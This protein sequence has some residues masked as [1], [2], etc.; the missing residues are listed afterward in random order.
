ME[1]IEIVAESPRVFMTG[2]DAK[3][4][5]PNAD[6]V[7]NADIKTTAIAAPLPSFAESE[8]LKNTA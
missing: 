4:R 7:V 2:C 5:L 8:Y 1:N 6:I 3:D